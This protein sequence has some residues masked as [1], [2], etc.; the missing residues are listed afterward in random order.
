[1][2][3]GLAALGES[4]YSDAY[5]Y[6]RRL[7]DP[8]DAAYHPMRHC[9]AIGDLAE[10]AVQSGHAEEVRALTDAL[11]GAA[12]RTPS[13]LFHASMRQARALLA[14][15]T[16]AEALYEAA[17]RADSPRCPFTRAR[18]QLAFGTWL[19]RMRRPSDARAPLRAAIEG[20]DALRA[21][22][23]GE[24]AR[25]ELRA[26]G[27]TSRAPTAEPLD[28][29]TA[30]ELQIALMAAEGLSNREIGERL[31]LSHR[32]VSSHFYRIF[33]K[34]GVTSRYQLRSV[35]GKDAV[36]SSPFRHDAVT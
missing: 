30:Q 10:A 2:A 24:K 7:F 13:P 23:W 12:R 14:D 35:L 1:M 31:Y 8:D 27:I 32:T 33:P 3:R 34:L 18:L 16:R 17:L 9:F 20:F 36:R 25:N 5:A 11:E 26:A 28:Q 21:L 15:D 22:P 6:L 29:L 4:R 19:R